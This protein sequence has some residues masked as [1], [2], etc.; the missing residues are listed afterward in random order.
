[1]NAKLS[2]AAI[3]SLATAVVTASAMFAY[4]AVE[5]RTSPSTGWSDH[6]WHV[7]ALGALSYLAL[8]GVLQWTVVRPLRRLYRH[9]YRFALGHL[10]RVPA[11]SSV[12]EISDLCVAVNHM[13]DR[14]GMEV[15]RDAVGSIREE[16]TELR[17]AAAALPDEEG[18]RVRRHADALHQAFATLV[19]WR[20]AQH[21]PTAEQLPRVR[22]PSAH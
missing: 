14:L 15:D 8:L 22:L 12:R 17:K 16:L 5:H 20:A 2:I 3:T 11:T 1:M 13:V 10:D 6:L 7:A 19:H 4:A 18:S 9:L 21:V